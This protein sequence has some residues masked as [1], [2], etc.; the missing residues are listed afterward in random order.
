MLN[1][2]HRSADIIP[3]SPSKVAKTS[4]YFPY[5]QPQN[6]KNR[7]QT[8]VASYSNNYQSPTKSTKYTPSKT[9]ASKIAAKNF[10]HHEQTR[11]TP[12]TA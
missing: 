9:P 4:T 7:P 2:D 5:Q 3:Q 8:A 1:D 11:T 10:N 6:S 12:V